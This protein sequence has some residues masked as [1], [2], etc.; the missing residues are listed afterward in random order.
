M[1]RDAWQ[2]CD[3]AGWAALVFGLTLIWVAVP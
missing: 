1:S 3:L 2:M